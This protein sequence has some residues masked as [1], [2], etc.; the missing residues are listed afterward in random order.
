[1]RALLIDPWDRSVSVVNYPGGL[2]ALYRVLDCGSIDVLRWGAGHFLYL[3]DVGVH[4]PLSTQRYWVIRDCPGNPG[5][6]YPQPLA[7]RALL[8]GNDGCGGDSDATLEPDVVFGAVEWICLDVVR[9]LSD[10]GSFDGGW[11]APG[12]EREVLECRVNDDRVPGPCPAC[13]HPIRECGTCRA[14]IC[15]PRGCPSCDW[16]RANEVARAV[17]AIER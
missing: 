7:G 8:V 5:H 2:D 1:M 13:H 4:R 3:D 11:T 10:G 16:Q 12:G 6:P 15:N 17:E 14:L 9:A